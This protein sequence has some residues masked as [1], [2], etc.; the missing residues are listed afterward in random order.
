VRVFEAP[1]DS[2][3]SGVIEPTV[4][5]TLPVGRG[6]AIEQRSSAREIQVRIGSI[7]IVQEQAVAA[8]VAAPPAPAQ[9]VV[10]AQGGFDAFARL[11]TYAPWER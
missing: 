2:A 6:P 1:L 5:A 4:A 9:T 7:E 3:S 11:R 10:V 8:S